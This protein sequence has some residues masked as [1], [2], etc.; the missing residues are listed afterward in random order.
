MT[1][2]SFHGDPEV[3]EEMIFPKIPEGTRFLKVTDFEDAGTTKNGDPM[4]KLTLTDTEL[5]ITMKHWL[6]LFPAGSKAHGMTK[7]QLHVLLNK[8]VD[9]E[10]EVEPS[11]FLGRVFKA[12][13][14]YEAAPNGK[15]YPR[16]NVSTMQSL[17]DNV[18]VV[19]DADDKPL[20]DIPF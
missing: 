11:D 16:F 10:I 14:Y 5:Q 12:D 13:I 3:S 20:S 1:P 18:D 4:I 2:Y 6:M 8:P 9:G 15:E 7:R 17:G 19:K